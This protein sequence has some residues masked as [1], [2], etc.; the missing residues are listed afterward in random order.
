MMI[1]KNYRDSKI[2]QKRQQIDINSGLLVMITQL[3]WD[4]MKLELKMKEIIG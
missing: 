3:V 1:I 2:Y 4:A